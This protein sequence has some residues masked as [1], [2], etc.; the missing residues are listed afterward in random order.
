MRD[1]SL[2]LRQLWRDRNLELIINCEIETWMKVWE[3]LKMLW[4]HSPVAHVPA[5]FHVLPNLY[6]H[7][8]NSIETP[9]MF[10]V[11]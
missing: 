3:N 1:S 9:Y 7:F 6:L 5:A 11:S 4:K 2:G 8:Y 10:F